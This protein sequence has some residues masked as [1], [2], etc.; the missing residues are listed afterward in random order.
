MTIFRIANTSSSVV[1][2]YVDKT[3]GNFDESVKTSANV[4][5]LYTP[6]SAAYKLGYTGTFTTPGQGPYTYELSFYVESYGGAGN[7]FILDFSNAVA[8]TGFSLIINNTTKTLQ[9]LAARTTALL[10]SSSVIATGRWYHVAVVKTPVVSN[11]SIEQNLKL[12]VDGYLESSNTD[13]I[14]SYSAFP[15]GYPVLGQSGGG[16]AINNIFITNFRYINTNLFSSKAANS[17]S[18][19]ASGIAG[20]LSSA[21]PIPRRFRNVNYQIEPL[22][23]LVYTPYIANT[24]PNS[25]QYDKTG[26]SYQLSNNALNTAGANTV[27]NNNPFSAKIPN[28]NSATLLYN[29]NSTLSV[30]SINEVDLVPSYQGSLSF[31]GSSQ[32]VTYSTN[33]AQGISRYTTA[34]L[35]Y[36]D[37]TTECWV[38]FSALTT[39]KVFFCSWAT[40]SGAWYLST[41]V[42]SATGISFVWIDNGATASVSSAAGVVTTSTWYHI[43]G[44][45]QSNT[46]GLFVNGT[47]VANVANFPSNIGAFGSTTLGA[48]ANGGSFATCNISNARFVRGTSVYGAVSNFTPP[49][50]P[51]TNVPGTTFL[52]STNYNSANAAL[53]WADTSPHGF[54]S[55]PWSL[56]FPTPSTLKPNWTTTPRSRLNGYGDL[57]ING[58]FDEKT[59]SSTNS[60]SVSFSGASGAGSL[61]I[62]YQSGRQ[63][64]HSY[65]YDT[66]CLGATGF[67]IECWIKLNVLPSVAGV[68][69][70]IVDFRT[71]GVSF[72]PY[73]QID[74]SN[75]LSWL[76]TNWAS[77]GAGVVTAI[78]SAGTWYHIVLQRIQAFQAQPPVLYYDMFINGS[79]TYAAG[80]SDTTTYSGSSSYLTNNVIIGASYNSA[81]Y[82]DGYISNFRLTP[83]ITLY[84]N[85]GFTSPT[86]ALSVLP[87]STILTCASPVLKDLSWNNYTVTSTGTIPPS[88]SNN[89]PF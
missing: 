29:A 20:S 81:N 50:S 4:Y 76:G 12:Y 38:Y 46:F 61:S 85:T 59:V 8:S 58:V 55:T 37:F 68:A 39:A 63:H 23:Q 87:A 78:A 80:A 88:V 60:Y 45:R 10:T 14:S 31:N 44:T 21:F 67:T 26:L 22:S 64:P 33:N 54:S 65:N 53:S 72:N 49:D 62:N 6:S 42:S 41:G 2:Y 19:A 74:T 75:K 73:L 86:S 71:S 69:Y 66:Y 1:T 13:S 40:T 28:S 27:S 70:T 43:V 83:G 25:I 32:F 17:A 51:L 57:L 89:A 18:A 7:Y 3:S 77:G 24:Y 9:H 34:A 84:A 36:E 82:F 30:S 48:F 35:G 5:S 56:V 52:A 11:N 79:R 16:S 15:T 47:N